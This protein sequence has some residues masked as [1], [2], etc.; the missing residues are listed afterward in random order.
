MSRAYSYQ[1]DKKSKFSEKLSNI[2]GIIKRKSGP[3]KPE[4]NESKRPEK[5]NINF[6]KLANGKFIV[7]AVILLAAFIFV[8]SNVTGYMTY[9]D[10]VEKQLNET[11]TNL[12]ETIL[13]YGACQNNLIN[14]AESDM[15]TSKN[16]ESC[17]ANMTETRSSYT[18]LEL[19]Y[20]K[21]E[22]ILDLCVS[23]KESYINSYNAWKSNYNKL[24]VSSAKAMCCSDNTEGLNITFTVTPMHAIDCSGVE[25]MINCT[26]GQAN[27]P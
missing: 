27:Y 1:S 24:I 20:S 4:I 17:N 5:L 14:C 19:N 3:K 26:T 8:G 18:L 16:L 9:T 15:S 23:E 2:T 21:K 25:Y 6:P 22:A 10:S 11:Q 13:L 7:V 12:N